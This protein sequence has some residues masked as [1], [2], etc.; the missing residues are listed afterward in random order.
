MKK[1]LKTLFLMIVVG[2]VIAG[3][4]S[5]MSKKR[6]ESKSDDEIREFLARKLDGKVGE[7]QLTTIQDAVIGG[8]RGKSSRT[9]AEPS[10]DDTESSVADIA[11]DQ[12][13]EVDDADDDAD[14]EGDD[15]ASGDDDADESS[16][17]ASAE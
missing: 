1:L 10:D 15:V 8:I 14:D 4:A 16:E 7:E 6:L 3:V 17:K 2:L 5:I 9:E 12:A 13:D 11:D